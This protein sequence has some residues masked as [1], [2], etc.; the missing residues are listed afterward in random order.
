MLPTVV[1][2]LMKVN[3]CRYDIHRGL[4]VV[5][6]GQGNTDSANYK[7]AKQAL[8]PVWVEKIEQVEE[9]ISKIQLKS[10]VLPI[11]VYLYLILF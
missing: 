3:F 9:D 6:F 11:L 5:N 8:P 7:A 10:K 1:T 2:A 4:V